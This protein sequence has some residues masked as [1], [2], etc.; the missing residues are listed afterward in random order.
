MAIT[1]FTLLPMA[2]AATI[3]LALLLAGAPGDGGL[4]GCA[5]L[6][7]APEDAKAPQGSS[8]RNARLGV[9]ARS[10]VGWKMV[11]DKGTTP[12]NWKRLVTFNDKATDAQ[13]VLSFR[14]RTVTSVDALMASTRRAWSKSR[15]GLRLDSIKK[16]E[17]SGLSPIATV[18]VEGSFTREAKPQAAI[19]FSCSSGVSGMP[20]PPW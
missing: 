1:R 16:T 3:L 11:V 14:P 19:N 20:E 5:A 18:V 4:F 17:A 6:E 13:A 15:G 12:T 9:S 10:P 7:A 8:Y 2:L